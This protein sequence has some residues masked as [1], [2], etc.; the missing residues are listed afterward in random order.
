VGGL[1]ISGGAGKEAFELGAERDAEAVTERGLF[2]E[3]AWDVLP[4][5]PEDTAG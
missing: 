3:E 5:I 2:E 4:E 1:L